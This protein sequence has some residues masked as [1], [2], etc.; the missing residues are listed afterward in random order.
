M[1]RSQMSPNGSTI[2]AGERGELARLGRGGVV[3]H[4]QPHRLARALGVDRLG[5]GGDLELRGDEGVLP[6]LGVGRKADP[7]GFVRGPFGQGSVR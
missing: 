5:E 2:D 7:H 3:G 1:S 6:Q 4:D